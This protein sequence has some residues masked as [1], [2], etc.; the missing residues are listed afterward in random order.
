MNFKDF[1]YIG[2]IIDNK[3][4]QMQISV[5]TKSFI[6]NI[7]S[8]DLVIAFYILLLNLTSLNQIISFRTFFSSKDIIKA[9]HSS[10]EFLFSCLKFPSVILS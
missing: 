3:E 9:K 2:K 6:T 7:G 4:F 10:K 8:E 1:K 5:F